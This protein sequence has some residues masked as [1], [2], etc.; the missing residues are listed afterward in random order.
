MK[1]MCMI[2]IGHFQCTLTNVQLQFNTHFCGTGA[3]HTELCDATLHFLGKLN[4][5]S[6][7]V[8][9]STFHLV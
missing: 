2:E 3:R 1:I 5:K 9:H 7:A 6:D 4:V 8:P